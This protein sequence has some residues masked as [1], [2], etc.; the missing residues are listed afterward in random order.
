M[1]RLQ[2]QDYLAQ[3]GEALK[4]LQAALERE[5]SLWELLETPLMLWVAM[6]AY[7]DAPIQ[8]SGEDNLEQRRRRIFASFVDA[9]F[10]RRSAALR[11][12]PKQTLEWLAL[13]AFALS[14]N[15]Q[16]IFHLENLRLS[17]LPKC[18][19]RWL[20]KVGIM[21]VSGGVCG[22][23]YAPMYGLLFRLLMLGFGLFGRF[24]TYNLFWGLGD[25][26]IGGLLVGLS[27]GLVGSFADIRPID[28]FR[29]RLTDIRYQAVRAIVFGLRYGMIA[30][31]S[32]GLIFGLN[33]WLGGNDV[34]R[35]HAPMAG[36]LVG[37]LI[38]LFTAFSLGLVKLIT[39]EVVEGR[40]S[41]NQGTR[42]SARHAIG[43][44]L[45]F[46]L[47]GGVI[48]GLWF[49]QS[50]GPVFGLMFGLIGGLFSGGLFAIRHVFLRLMLS[51][52]RLAPMAYRSFLDYAA[53]RLFLRKVG[54]GYVF[55]HRTLLE[56]FASLRE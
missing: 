4:G 27:G 3:A 24:R 33:Q 16:T 13:L 28:M 52:S 38:A 51:M 1:N 20:S 8:F 36:L 7:R 11:Y 50:D 31:L 2:I 49:G 12:G 15:N 18:S 29:V 45:I 54:G 44:L 22:L 9:M 26:L 40:R 37:V 25:W 34:Q 53:E 43:A 39:L 35:S 14:R 19:Q 10:K 30:G 17:W 46:G 48:S 56:Y 41:P 5:P 55:A 6:L 32:F 21:I 23:I 47:I 42:N